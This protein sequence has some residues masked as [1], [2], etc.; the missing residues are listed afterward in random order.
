[1]ATRIE[2]QLRRE[3]LRQ[4]LREAALKGTLA[5]GEMVPPVRELA[6]RF[7][8]SVPVALEVV[9]GLV[10]E[11]VLTTVPS[12][13]TFVGRPT[14]S[15][16]DIYLLVN[17]YEAPGQLDA[18]RVGFEDRVSQLGGA[19]L[20]LDERAAETYFA[21][22][23][24]PNVAG[25]FR[26]RS[27]QR[28]T[29]W[30][31]SDVRQV[32]FGHINPKKPHTDMVYFDNKD[33]GTQATQ[34]LLQLGHSN[35]AF[36][37]LHAQT[38]GLGE[39]VWSQEREQGWQNTMQASGH[40]TENLLFLPSLTSGSNRNEQIETARQTAE[41]LIARS[42]ITGVVAANSFAARGFFEALQNAHIPIENWP[43][44]VTFD[45]Y[46]VLDGYPATSLRLPWE[47]IG[48]VAAELL[49]QRRQK[50]ISGPP[51]QRLVSMRLISRLSC[52]PDWARSLG[53]VSNQSAL[54]TA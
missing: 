40:E 19:S 36:L 44:V 1:M 4:F 46:Q 39:F 51:Q 5:A 54:I 3:K 38:G 15:Q 11:G 14:I 45:S 25:V 29:T 9:K 21:D 35:I 12:V 34:H 33:G 32:E 49:W 24:H 27:P 41:A 17:I 20:V 48:K 30:E 42:D 53:L 28:E 31:I 2:T 23:A 10:E 43:A 22:G 26:T 16:P 50:Q 8:L 13:G 52:R 6:T 47:E 7:E 37:G 18:L